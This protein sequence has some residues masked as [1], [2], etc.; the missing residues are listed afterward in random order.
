MLL[1]RVIEH[2]RRQEWTAIGIDFAIVVIGVFVGIQVANWNERRR[3]HER[4]R[5][6]LGRIAAELDESVRSI[7]R[8]NA[9]TRERMALNQFLIDS[10]ADPGLVRTDP[11][12][13]IYA[14]TRGGY[15][16][17]PSVH[18]YTFEEIKSRGDLG[19]FSDSQLSLDLMAFYAEVQQ[20]A[21]W[22]QLRALSQFEYIRRSAGIL[23]AAQLALEPDASRAIRTDDVDGTV[24]AHERM[25]A[26]P[27]FVEWV[28][29]TLD[30]RRTDLQYGDQILQAAQDLR[31]RV[32]A[33][34]GQPSAARDA[35][36]T[37]PDPP[38]GVGR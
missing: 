24:A 20:K 37:A 32:R 2:V 16:F 29:V 22:S 4:E 31:D 12:R 35:T 9:L 11:G 34:L 28:P 26:R 38:G 1:R 13:F 25:L 3:D 30:Y 27:E 36:A 23:D 19:I 18:G 14:M 5:A 7:E 21:Q 33:A 10:A 15:T 6:Y 17:S 8:S